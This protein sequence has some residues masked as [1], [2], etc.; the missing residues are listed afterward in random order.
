MTCDGASYVGEFDYV[1]EIMVIQ[2][3]KYLAHVK[4]YRDLCAGS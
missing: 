1:N 4:C 2:C 3:V